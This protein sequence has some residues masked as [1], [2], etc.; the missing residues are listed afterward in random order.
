MAVD[1]RGTAPDHPPGEAP[2]PA[3]VPPGERRRDR[4]RLVAAVVLVGGAVAVWE[5][6]A[7]HDD[8]PLLGGERWGWGSCLSR[9]SPAAVDWTIGGVLAEPTAD[10]VVLDV[11]AV[12]PQNVVVREG[13][14]LPFVGDR[15]GDGDRTLLGDVPGY[16]PADAGAADVVW[17]QGDPLVGAVLVHEAPTNLTWR[18]QV[19]DPAQDARYEA[20]EIEYRSGHRR[21]VAVVDHDL[22]IPGGA[23]ACPAR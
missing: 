6:G 11:R 13:T 16:P 2:E 10:V 4:A 20:V 5:L 21:Y 19:R 23:A 14:V 15:D 1:T 12:R 8:E 9:S 22:L 7:L 3:A 17:A 18:A